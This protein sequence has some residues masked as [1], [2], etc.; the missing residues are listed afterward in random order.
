M[1]RSAIPALVV[2]FSL[3]AHAQSLSDAAATLKQAQAQFRSCQDGKLQLAFGP[4]L[5][6][7]EASRQALEKGRRETEA[8]RRS[9]E[10]TRKRIEA[11]HQARHL[12]AEERVAKEEQYAQSLAANYEQPMRALQPLVASYVAGIEQ[13]AGV[14]HQYADFCATGHVTTA[15]AREFVSAVRPAVDALDGSAKELVAS[16]SHAA[17]GDVAAR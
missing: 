15:S 12:S 8:A 10:A 17:A 14:I 9:L 13:Y 2:F 1:L 5:A 16:A 6:R 3:S 7:L 11:A 4:V